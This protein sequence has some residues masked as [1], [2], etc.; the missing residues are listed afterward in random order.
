MEALYPENKNKNLTGEDPIVGFSQCPNYAD[1]AVAAGGAWGTKVE[2]YE[3]LE[4]AL[5]TGIGKVKNGVS[6]VVDCVVQCV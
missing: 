6:A 5:V 4:G 2:E 3:A 1:I